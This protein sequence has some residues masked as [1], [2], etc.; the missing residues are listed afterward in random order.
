MN[1]KQLFEEIKQL[2][3]KI[4]D[5]KARIRDLEEHIDA[6]VAARDWNM[7]KAFEE[8]LNS[9]KALLDS[10]QTLLRSYISLYGNN[11]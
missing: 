8:R 1:S 5:T 9:N 3:Q 10:Q 2:N 11:E 7:V 6:N 4:Q